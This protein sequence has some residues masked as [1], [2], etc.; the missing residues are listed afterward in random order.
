MLFPVEAG[1]AVG[2]VGAPPVQVVA[3]GVM[4]F[5]TVPVPEYEMYIMDWEAV[6][7]L[8]MTSL[9]MSDDS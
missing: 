3:D 6:H 1:G 7:I 4:V 5:V 8:L 2:A 9:V